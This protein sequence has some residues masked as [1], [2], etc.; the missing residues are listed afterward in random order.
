[1][2]RSISQVNYTRVILLSVILVAYNVLFSLLPSELLNLLYV[3]ANLVFAAIIFLGARKLLGIS[4]A[5]VGLRSDTLKKGTIWGFSVGL[6]IVII[7]SLGIYFLG[8][9]DRLSSSY[10]ANPTTLADLLFRI[11]IRIPLGTAL[12]EEILFRGILIAL[13]VSNGLSNIKCILISCIVFGLWHIGLALKVDPEIQLFSW[14]WLTTA[15]GTIGMGLIGGLVF[16][17][18]RFWTNSLVAPML[19]H[20]LIN[21]STVILVYLS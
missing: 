19:V 13:L 12:V 11:F 17:F 4:Y 9:M 5:D 18:M 7:L 1:M 8:F 15:M 2:V 10:E 3:P 16:A 6:T 21:I 14:A 20:W